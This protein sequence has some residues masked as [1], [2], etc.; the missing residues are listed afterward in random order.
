MT[1][2]AVAAG[3]AMMRAVDDGTVKGGDAWRPRRFE[4]TAPVTN[5]TWIRHRA[6]MRRG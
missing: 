5:A 4:T 1:H 6:V 3:N 2:A